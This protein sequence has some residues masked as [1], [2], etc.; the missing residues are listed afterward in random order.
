VAAEPGH[1]SPNRLSAAVPILGWLPSYRRAWLGCDVIAGVIVVCLLVPE[2]M[3]YAQIAGMPPETAFYVAPPAL[4]LYT[5]F[6]S[7]RKLV[8]VVSATQAALSAGAV[9]L[10]RRPALPS[11]KS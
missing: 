6:A 3:A 1:E 7:S 2:G 10:S 5:I 4:L 8:V 11:T 9:Q